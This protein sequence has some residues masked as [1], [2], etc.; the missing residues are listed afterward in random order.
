M[1]TAHATD[2]LSGLRHEDLVSML[3]SRFDVTA[4][5]VDVDPFT[6][7]TVERTSA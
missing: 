7:R 1:H 3:R 2:H 4:S 6:T 5:V